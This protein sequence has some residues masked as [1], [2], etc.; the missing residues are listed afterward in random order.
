MAAGRTRSRGWGRGRG[1]GGVVTER[2][3][4]EARLV[5]RSVEDVVVALLMAQAEQIATLRAE[6]D[7][8]K[9]RVGQSS[10][11]SSKP[12]SSD[13]PSVSKREKREGSGRRPG[14]QPGHEGHRRA[15]VENPDLTLTH[16]PP[17]CSGC[18]SDL[19]GVA[20]DGDPFVAGQR[21][22]A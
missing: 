19:A 13:P 17:S 11:N 7:E 16:R 12:P 6:M 1:L 3:G 22:L 10:R 5:Y 20:D 18:G 2:A 15:I 4:D 14:G 9:R 21:L 8:L